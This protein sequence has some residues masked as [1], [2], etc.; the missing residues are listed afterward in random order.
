[1]NNGRRFQKKTTWLHYLSIVQAIICLL[2]T[3]KALL[4]I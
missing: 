2:Q 3:F 4:L 1:M